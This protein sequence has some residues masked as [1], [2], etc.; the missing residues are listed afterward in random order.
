MD[1]LH[2]AGYESS[3]S[4]SSSSRADSSKNHDSLHKGNAQNA[5]DG[6]SPD[7]T[8]SYGYN[9]DGSPSQANGN[10]SKKR[11]LRGSQRSP[12]TAKK[13]KLAQNT[14]IIASSCN[15]DTDCQQSDQSFER[16]NPHWEGRWAGHIYLPFQ[17][18]RSLDSCNDDTSVLDD[19]DEDH[20]GTNGIADESESDGDE[21]S[22]SS[23]EE[24]E[25][26][27]ASRSLLPTARLLIH[28][29][30]D[31]LKETFHDGY[32][33]DESSILI[34]PHLPMGSSKETS[35]NQEEYHKFN[36]G[37]SLHISLSRPIYLP[38]PSVDP[39]FMDISSSISSV[40]SAVAHRHSHCNSRKGRTIHLR[41]HDATIF[42]NDDQTRSFLA[43]PISEESSR[44]I[45]RV[46]LPPIDAVINRFGQKTYYTEEGCI[47]HV[48]IASVKGNMISTILKRR[49]KDVPVQ[50]S[51]SGNVVNKARKIP[52]FQK[53]DCNPLE[54]DV[55]NSIPESIPI[56][57]EH[58]QC[59]FGR[60]K[61]MLLSL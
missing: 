50:R 45:K 10:A 12:A 53:E 27:Q 48:S 42:I 59:D 35:T 19:K 21:S 55:L 41:P 30:A 32:S 29:W 5:V 31:I 28:Y 40:L 57:L 6:H 44:W 25:G 52:L 58:I 43:I 3:S 54:E 14:V 38:A 20:S 11:D 51:G 36:S 37:A 7:N 23:I 24:D 49:V 9:N 2:A 22:V 15:N 33:D 8:S 13:Q 18:M 60:V 4:S 47:L 56:R 61:R 46:L 34:V 17:N 1:L 39:F 26:L 16:S